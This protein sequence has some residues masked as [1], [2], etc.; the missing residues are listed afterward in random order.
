MERSLAFPGV[1]PLDV[2]GGCYERGD[3]ACV[4]RTA[5]SIEEPT[6]THRRYLF[7]ALAEQHEWDALRDALSEVPASAAPDYSAFQALLWRID[8]DLPP[9]SPPHPLAAFY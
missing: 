3:F 5:R 4:V 6:R 2:L 9:G 1:D 8:H 7:S